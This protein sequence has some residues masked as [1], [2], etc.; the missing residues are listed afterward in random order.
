MKSALFTAALLLAPGLALADGLNGDLTGEWALS[1]SAG[2]TPITMHCTLLQQGQKLDGSCSH[3]D[4]V[5]G[6]SFTGTVKGTRASWSYDET[7]RGQPDHVAINA[8]IN[9][10]RSMSGKLMLSGRSAPFTATKE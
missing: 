5:R 2:K 8:K 7:V 6:A 3:A 9:A 10:D 1:S 4:G